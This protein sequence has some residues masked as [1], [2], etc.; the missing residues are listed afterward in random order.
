[1]LR[2][3]KFEKV[4]YGEFEKGFK[5]CFPQCELQCADVYE[6]LKLPKRATK[7]SAGY[8]FFAP[9]TLLKLIFFPFTEVILLCPSTI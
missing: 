6:Q 1:M 2:I 7:G 3:A 8:D 4:S 9:V 5:D